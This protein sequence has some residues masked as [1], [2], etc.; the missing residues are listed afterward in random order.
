MLADLPRFRIANPKP[1]AVIP[2]VVEVIEVMLSGGDF[3]G[4]RCGLMTVAG[5]MSDG[6]GFSGGRV[7]GR[8]L[9]VD[10]APFEWAASAGRS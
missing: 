1:L 9:I 5:G 10:D 2:V 7:A 4:I 3:N 6:G 8:V